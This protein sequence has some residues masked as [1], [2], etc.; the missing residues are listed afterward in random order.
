MKKVL[1]I[2]AIAL[3]FAGCAA[4]E[5]DNGGN[6]MYMRRLLS[7]SEAKEKM[8]NN[9][10]VIILDVRNRNEFL[11]GHIPGALLLPEFEIAENVDTILPDTN[12]LILVY[13]RSGVRSRN[14]VVLLVSLGYTNVYDFGGI[15]NWPY[16]IVM[17]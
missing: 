14:A 11:S 1:L 8:Q 2:A 12:A 3:M 4:T 5:T 10:D 16:D 6:D 9:P 7:A 15:I 13:C 17:P